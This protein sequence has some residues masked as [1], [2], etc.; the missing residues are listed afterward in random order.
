MHSGGLSQF[1]PPRKMHFFTDVKKTLDFFNKKTSYSV[2]IVDKY[3][4]IWL[5]LMFHQEQLH[6]L[7]IAAE[8]K[9]LTLK[10]ITGCHMQYE[11]LSS[12]FTS[13][14]S[15]LKELHSSVYPFFSMFENKRLKWLAF[16]PPLFLL[17][18]ANSHNLNDCIC[19]REDLFETGLLPANILTIISAA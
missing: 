9:I 14:N 13:D 12:A 8:R 18:G 15:S 6:F 11:A 2:R 17:L 16:P 3:L 5:F 4:F 1:K 19:W 10:K 7:W